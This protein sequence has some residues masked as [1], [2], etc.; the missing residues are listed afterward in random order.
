MSQMTHYSVSPFPARHIF[1]PNSN[2]SWSLFYCFH[3]TL[4]FTK[5][6]QR[7]PEYWFPWGI[8]LQEFRCQSPL[9]CGHLLLNAIHYK[10]YISAWGLICICKNQPKASFPPGIRHVWG[11]VFFLPKHFP[12]GSQGPLNS[13]FSLSLPFFTLFFKALH[14]IMGCLAWRTPS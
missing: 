7:R 3:T 6:L 14:V 10:K 9:I 1:V 4:G 8:L 12:A 13:H 5:E 11:V 2:K